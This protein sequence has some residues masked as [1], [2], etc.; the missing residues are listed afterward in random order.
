MLFDAVSDMAERTG[1]DPCLVEALVAVLAAP[2]PAW[3]ADALCREHPE[4]SFFPDRGEPTEPAKAVCSTCLVHADCARWALDQDAQ[5]AGIWAG[6]SGKQRRT[7]RA[8]EDRTTPHLGRRPGLRAPSATVAAGRAR[9]T[10]T[11]ERASA[12]LAAHPDEDH[13][14]SDMTP[15]AGSSSVLDR[16]YV[17]TIENVVAVAWRHPPHRRVS[18][19]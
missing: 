1:A 4:V 2:R 16:T 11:M 10:K 8:A 7:I 9:P 3:H 18:G 19:S 15:A 14:A 5:L 17:A 13:P 6:S 12:F